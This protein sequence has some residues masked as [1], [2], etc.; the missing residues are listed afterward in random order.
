MAELVAKLEATTQGTDA[1]VDIDEKIAKLKSIEWMVEYM[2]SVQELA[3]R[4]TE[5]SLTRKERQV[6]SGVDRTKAAMRASFE[7]NLS[8]LGATNDEGAAVTKAA[9]DSLERELRR[10]GE[11][12]DAQLTLL[13]SAKSAAQPSASVGRSSPVQSFSRSPVAHRRFKYLPHMTDDSHPDS[14]SPKAADLFVCTG[15]G[16]GFMEAANRG[17]SEV[18][19][20]RSIGMG[21]SLPFETGLNPYVTPDLAFEYHCASR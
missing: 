9:V 3:R 13:A 18:P 1:R 20:G 10:A 19:G 17:A 2:E 21:I 7:R 4:I 11:L 15:G 5:W 16:P 8:E 14:V 12:N 6:V